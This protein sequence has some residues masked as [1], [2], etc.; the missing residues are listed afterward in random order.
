MFNVDL[1]ADRIARTNLQKRR[2]RESERQDRIFNDKVRTIGVDKE[3][4]NMQINE[5]VKREQAAKEEQKTYDAD[6]L[7]NS[8]VAC[9]V[10]SRQVK[11]KREMEKAVVNFRNQY[12]QPW[13]QREFDLNDPDRC[14]KTDPGDVQMMLPGLVGEDPDSKS[15]QQRQKEQLREWLIQQQSERAAERHQQNLDEQR[16]NQSRV[17][18]DNTALQ[19]H[20]TEMEKRK[21]AAIAT[22]EYNLAQIEEKRRNVEERHDNR[23][24]HL[25]ELLTGADA[26]PTLCMVGVPGLCPSSDRRAPP[27]SLQ[28]ISQFQKYQI[29]ENKKLQLQKNKEEEQYD[30]V[31]LDSA[32]AAL[33]I[34][35]QQA[36]LNKQ[37]RQHLDSTNIKLAETHKQQKPDIERGCI[38]DSF[39]S[40]FNTCSR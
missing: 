4:L 30:R 22:K 12:Q 14:R 24:G 33:L 31:R 20:C 29:E 10:H 13:S 7:H 25:Q 40:K 36:R 19:L 1:L 34:E 3:A 8:K 38:E 28:Q 37:L 16:Y 9:L 35:R 26:E 17:D 32:R 23:A 39:F 11:E 2:N 5:K 21:A 15:R 27:E 18:M 6:M